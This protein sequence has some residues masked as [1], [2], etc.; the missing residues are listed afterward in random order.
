MTTSTVSSA[1]PASRM[2]PRPPRE[3]LSW[4]AATAVTPPAPAPVPAVSA[5]ALVGAR[6]ALQPVGAA[7]KAAAAILRLGPEAMALPAAAAAASEKRRDG[8]EAVCL[9]ASPLR[10]L[11]PAAAA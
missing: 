11:P 3:P 6:V 1:A 10:P 9:S 5:M 4:P 8:A 7:R 2:T